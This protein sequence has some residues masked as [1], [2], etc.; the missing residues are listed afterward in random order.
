MD[1]LEWFRHNCVHV[2]TK[3]DRAI[4]RN[5]I[6][7][8]YPRRLEYIEDHWRDSYVYIV[9][10]PRSGF[11]LAGSPIRGVPHELDELLGI[12]Y[13]NTTEEE[14]DFDNIL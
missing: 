13:G 9:G 3:E 12:Y 5:M 10:S 1:L 7:T 8:Q 2:P 4:V 6:A 11:S 14:V